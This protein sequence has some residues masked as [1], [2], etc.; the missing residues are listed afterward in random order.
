MPLFTYTDANASS[1]NLGRQS[2]F[3]NCADV[4]VDQSHPNY[5]PNSSDPNTLCWTASDDTNAMGVDVVYNIGEDEE[6]KTTYALLVNKTLNPA[7]GIA[8]KASTL[9]A[10]S[11]C[12][13]LKNGCQQSAES[14]VASVDCEN[15]LNNMSWTW[16]SFKI[17]TS[18]SSVDN[19]LT[20]IWPV[21]NQ[22]SRYNF[23]GS[24]S[25]SAPL[26]LALFT[27]ENLSSQY[28]VNYEFW[29]HPPNLSQTLDPTFSGRLY[30]AIVGS[31][32]GSL[33]LPQFTADQGFFYPLKNYSGTTLSLGNHNQYIGF[34][35]QCSISFA[36]VTYTYV[37][38]SYSILSVSDVAPQT[39]GAWAFY[40]GDGDANSI[41][42]PPAGQISVEDGISEILWR[43][44][45]SSTDTY[46][47]QNFSLALESAVRMT[48]AAWLKGAAAP[49][50]PLTYQ[51]RKS[52]P[53]ATKVPK[54]SLITLVALNCIYSLLGLVASVFAWS[55]V[56]NR[57]GRT[58][59]PA[60]PGVLEIAEL[61]STKGLTRLGTWTGDGN[62][63]SAEVRLHLYQE[64]S[65]KRY[66]FVRVS[67]NQGE[68]S[69]TGA[70]QTPVPEDTS[71]L[72]ESGPQKLSSTHTENS[73]SSESNISGAPSMSRI[74]PLSENEGA[75][76]A[77]E[78]T[79][80]DAQ[81]A[82]TQSSAQ[83][84]MDVES[85]GSRTS[86]GAQPRKRN[87]H[88]SMGQSQH[89]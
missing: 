56:Y 80:S 21:S 83:Q 66:G 5:L 45:S 38:G 18:A 24:S 87:T 51:S 53:N 46:T 7:T 60:A 3:I 81:G 8:Y 20:P 77:R 78:T 36:N 68:T 89:I 9:A 67:V 86:T 37:D 13:N 70:A 82:T 2:A 42:P 26:G 28:N 35:Y 71:S 41:S 54:D 14:D 27:D 34:A 10:T 65:R 49:A 52:W 40:A 75:L 74:Q 85:S 33:T 59:R 69:A 23:S 11:S 32:Y 16:S 76:E 84:A 29:R 55:T 62:Y 47:S 61:F 44:L 43:N 50:P 88:P 4:P 30:S 64:G 72:H 6:D 79:S 1:I 25:A 39:Y 73:S 57:Q 31:F 22:E 17:E 48:A 58:S 63:E 19:T 15:G 12:K